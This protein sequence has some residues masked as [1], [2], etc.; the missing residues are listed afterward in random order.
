[1]STNARSTV[2]TWDT[3]YEWKAA[4]CSGSASASWDSIAGSSRR[5]GAAVVRGAVRVLV[6]PSR[7]RGADHGAHRH[8]VRAARLDLVVDRRR[9]GRGRDLR[10]R[11]RADHR[12]RR[13][14]SLRPAERALRRAHGAAR[15][16]RRPDPA[17]AHAGGIRRGCGEDPHKAKGFRLFRAADGSSRPIAKRPHRGCGAYAYPYNPQI[18]AIAYIDGLFA[19][20]YQ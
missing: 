4:P 13:R 17:K 18:H 1:M 11:H 20:A 2:T 5:R 10:R 3:S 6:L 15:E 7:Q 9:G 8:G 14:G 16:A 19:F 12:G